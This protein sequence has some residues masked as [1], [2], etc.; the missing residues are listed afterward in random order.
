[1]KKISLNISAFK[2]AEAIFKDLLFEQEFDN[3]SETHIRAVKLLKA[4]KENLDFDIGL[5]ER[6]CGDNTNYPYRSSWYLTRFFKDLGFNYEH[7]Q[8]TRRFW[9]EDVLKELSILDLVTVVEKGLFRKRDFQNPKFRPEN[10]KEMETN[11]FVQIA[12]KDF[13][14]FID[15]S[16]SANET[17]SLTEILDLNVN[18]ELL[19]E[20]SPKTRDEELNKLIE[21]AKSRFL[22][23]NDK[24][25]ALEKL[26]DA[27]ERLKTYFDSG[28]QKKESA[29]KLVSII[30]NNFDKDF[31]DDEFKKLTTIGNNYR[32]RHHETDKIEI[33]NSNHQ[34]YLFFRMLSLI[35]LC[36]MNLNEN[37]HN[38]QINRTP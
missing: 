27:F 25:I 13:R 37:T 35:D 6:I 36:L 26:W 1:M 15:E 23:P 32:I 28:K 21:D 22:N 10:K 8:G 3:T 11:D 18:I 30:S 9:V 4:R 2:Q 19:F 29:D 7:T 24:Q 14:K 34:S 12:I 16:L 5:A 20:S 17:V 31:F 33:K 38:P